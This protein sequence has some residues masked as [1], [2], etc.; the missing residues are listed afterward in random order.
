VP[1]L[2]YQAD[3]M[4]DLSVVSI[5]EIESCYYM[6][7]RVKDKPGVLADITRALAD[8]Q[9][10]IDAFIQREPEE[11]EDETDVILM[12]HLCLE[13]NMRDAIRAIESLSTVL[14]QAV[15]L[16]MESFA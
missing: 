7:L 11:G 12:T 15:V 1:P 6:R 14:S 2:S 16:R 3:A 5:D 13:K 8:R 9:I 4:S 10:S